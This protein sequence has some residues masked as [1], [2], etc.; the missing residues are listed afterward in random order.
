MAPQE[1]ERLTQHQPDDG[2]DGARGILVAVVLAFIAY[3]G[4]IA[5]VITWG[6]PW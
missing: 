4:V 3:A 1:Q 5:A 2:L 6:W